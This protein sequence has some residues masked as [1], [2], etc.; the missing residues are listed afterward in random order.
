MNSGSP[1]TYFKWGD[2]SFWGE[3][4]NGVDPKF[5]GGPIFWLQGGT[6]KKYQFLILI[7]LYF[8]HIAQIRAE[9]SV[10]ISRVFFSYCSDQGSSVSVFSEYL[11][12][13]ILGFEVSF[14]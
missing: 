11:R 6:P 13:Y 4:L 1:G 9:F 14:N 7:L 2:L 8:F 5:L 3:D 10:G 12:D